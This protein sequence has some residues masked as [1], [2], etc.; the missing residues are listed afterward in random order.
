MFKFRSGFSEDDNSYLSKS[1]V[2]RAREDLNDE[3]ESSLPFTDYNHALCRRKLAIRQ[4]ED[5]NRCSLLSL[6]GTRDLV[7]DMDV[8]R[9]AVMQNVMPLFRNMP[10]DKETQEV[11]HGCELMLTDV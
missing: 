3:L 1:Q 9:R 2:C 8:C 11:I 10:T 7:T 4:Y 6:Y 5:K